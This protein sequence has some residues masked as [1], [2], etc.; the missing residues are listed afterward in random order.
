S[1]SGRFSWWPWMLFPLV[2]GW[3]PTLNLFDRPVEVAL[4]QAV[5]H[6]AVLFE[7]ALGMSLG[8]LGGHLARTLQD[9]ALGELQ[10]RIW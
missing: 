7:L 10:K 1:N 9:V 2:A 6:D 3:A 4:K 8:H 5:L